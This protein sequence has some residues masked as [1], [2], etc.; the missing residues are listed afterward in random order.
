MKTGRHDNTIQI[1]QLFDLLRTSSLLEGKTTDIK[2]ED[3]IFLVEKYFD[4]SQT[5][6]TK[7]SQDKFNAFVEAN[8]QLIK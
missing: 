5:L 2:L 3:I 8:P 7:L 6:Q 1:E 4:P